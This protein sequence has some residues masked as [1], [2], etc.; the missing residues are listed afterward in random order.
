MNPFPQITAALRATFRLASITFCVVAVL[1]F[2]NQ[3]AGVALPG[4]F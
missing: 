4:A 1:W 2:V 3:V